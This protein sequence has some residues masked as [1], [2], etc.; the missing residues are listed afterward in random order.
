MNEG[1]A[2]ALYKLFAPRLDTLSGTSKDA[3]IK[4]ESGC[5]FM[6]EQV[7]IPV[8]AREIKEEI[9]NMQ[10]TLSTVTGDS[11]SCKSDS[12]NEVMYTNV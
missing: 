3:E 1:Q 8:W 5:A 7:D 10:R 2:I 11:Y 9:H 6:S 4:E 12:E